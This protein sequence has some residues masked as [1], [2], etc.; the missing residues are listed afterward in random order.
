MSSEPQAV[1]AAAIAQAPSPTEQV[2]HLSAAGRRTALILVLGV[3][4]VWVFAAWTLVTQALDGLSGPEWVTALL[5][6]GILV[7]APVVGWT[8]LEERSTVITADAHGLAYR[9]ITGIHL[10]Y[11]WSEVTDQA[12]APARPARWVRLFMDDSASAGMPLP[13]EQSPAAGPK[14]AMTHQSTT[15]NNASP[16]GIDD[17]SPPDGSPADAEDRNAAADEAHTRTIPVTVTPPPAARIAS[18]VIRALWRQAHGDTLPLP[19]E[20]ENRAAILAMIRAHRPT[21]ESSPPA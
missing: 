14:A 10:A 7:V 19:G 16:T 18:P 1:Q 5:M 4:A 21:P 3:A 6:L 9:S 15:S 13:T 2:Y 17:D 8:L 20:L 11:A 12:P